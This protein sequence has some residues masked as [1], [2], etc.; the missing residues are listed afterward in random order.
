MLQMA[1][2]GRLNIFVGTLAAALEEWMA[3]ILAFGAVAL[4]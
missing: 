3:A 1:R 2:S 4:F